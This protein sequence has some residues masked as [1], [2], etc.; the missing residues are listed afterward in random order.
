MS[1]EAIKSEIKSTLAESQMTTDVAFR[2][3]RDIQ[4]FDVSSGNQELMGRAIDALQAAEVSRMVDR[5]RGL[6]QSLNPEVQN[7]QNKDE[8]PKS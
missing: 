2:I 1:K 4:K 6:N 5:E 7:I 8:K 3:L